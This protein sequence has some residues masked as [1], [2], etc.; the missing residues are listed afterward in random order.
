MILFKGVIPVSQSV[1]Q[2]QHEWLRWMEN[3]RKRGA[4]ESGTMMVQNETT[5]S[6]QDISHING[7]AVV[8]V[9]SNEETIEVVNQASKM[10]P[11]GSIKIQPFEPVCARP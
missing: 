9:A 7:Y 3:L 8:K 10:V 6:M 4:F 5:D 11:G 1:R 2:K